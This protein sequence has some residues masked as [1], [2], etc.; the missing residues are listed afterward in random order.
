[1]D[2]TK[3]SE[4]SFGAVAF[5]DVLGFSSF[6]ENDAKTIEPKNLLKLREILKGVKDT[7]PDLD[8]RAFSDSIVISADLESTAVSRLLTTV[9][10][11]QRHFVSG[12]VLIRG[13]VAFGK[14][15]ADETLIYSE[16]LIRAY[17]LERDKARFPRILVA[18]DLIDWY[19]HNQNTQASDANFVRS[20][21]LTDRD[22]MD[23]IDYLQEEFIQSHL[24]TIS[25]YQKLKTTP[26]VLEKIQ[27]ICQ[28][29]NFSADRF[30]SP[31]K[32]DGPMLTG[33]HSITI[34]P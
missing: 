21:L 4:W 7:A 10:N 1:M 30:G 28:Y 27:W 25:A 33:F 18:K 3:N 16:A 34:K 20:I 8:V 23:F 32:Y 13:G 9:V 31:N 11:L 19:F 14:H 22:G 5:I 17:E 29:H 24:K 26:S 6:V 12:G 15:Y 2:N